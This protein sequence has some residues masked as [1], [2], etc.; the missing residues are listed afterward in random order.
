MKCPLCKQELSYARHD[1]FEGSVLVEVLADSVTKEE[2][3]ELKENF[4]HG[5]KA[6]LVLTP[7]HIK[8]NLAKCRE[9]QTNIT[10]GPDEKKS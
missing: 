1:T 5:K 7:N 8:H 9:L 4:L 3:K 2:I 10:P 6:E